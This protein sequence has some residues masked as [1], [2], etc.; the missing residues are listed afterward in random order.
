[1]KRATPKRKQK[2]A[3]NK[4]PA[5]L[6]ALAIT[7]S[8]KEAADAIGVD[9]SAHYA[10]MK[11]DPAYPA[12]FA[13]AQAQGMDALD[14]EATRRANHGVFEP[15]VYQGEFQYEQVPVLDPETG[16]QVRWQ[17]PITGGWRGKF[18]RGK[19][20]GVWRKSDGL[21]QFKLR[22]AFA[23]YRQ[24]VLEVTGK[25][26]GPIEMGIVER[27]N[28]ARNRLAALKPKADPPKTDPDKE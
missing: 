14:D 8:I 7:G 4:K 23:K 3:L 5:F 1:M 26:G 25:D 12:R 6:K 10:W 27:L 20:L 9:R 28:A 19:M 15:L 22:G 21:L 17:D 16:E 13:E 24:G 11:T 18:E 2:R